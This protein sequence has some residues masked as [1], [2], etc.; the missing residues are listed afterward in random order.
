V[1]VSNALGT[2]ASRCARLTVVPALD[3]E[4]AARQTL[5]VGGRAVLSVEVESAVPVT[6]QCGATVWTWLWGHE[7]HA[8]TQS[9][10]L[11]AGGRYSVVVRNGYGEVVSA[12]AEL[13][14]VAVAAWA[15]MLRSVHGF[16]RLR[17]VW[18][19]PGEGA[20][21][22]VACGRGRWWLGKE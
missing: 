5:T 2:V 1:T 21:S 20:Q 19:S 8:G 10:G 17:N 13:S 12:E 4:P 9:L 14:V 6:Y 3:H 15:T 22:G 18:R 16:R 11:E 7:R